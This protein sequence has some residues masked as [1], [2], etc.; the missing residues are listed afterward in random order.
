MISDHIA[1]TSDVA[2]IYPARF[3]DPFA[4]LARLAG[5]TDRIELGTSVAI[6][7][8]RSPLLPDGVMRQSGFPP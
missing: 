4:T 6:L 3:Y 5:H 2:A 7:Q 8:Y 1:L